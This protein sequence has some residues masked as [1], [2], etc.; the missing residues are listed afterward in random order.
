MSH[1]TA[2]ARALLSQ[3]ALLQA[4]NVMLRESRSSLSPATGQSNPNCIQNRRLT[5]I[6]WANENRRLAE[7][8]IK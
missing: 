8:Q 4:M 1:P 3:S 6:V 2:I 5:C 7:I